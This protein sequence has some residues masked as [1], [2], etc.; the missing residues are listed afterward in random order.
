[1]SPSLILSALRVALEPRIV[2]A[3]GTL[4]TAMDLEDA[5]DRLAT[6]PDRWRVILT[7]VRGDA[8]GEQKNVEL[9]NLLAVVQAH[10]GM[11]S[12]KKNKEDGPLLEKLEKVRGLIAAVR[13]ALPPVLP[14]TVPT[15]QHPEIDCAGFRRKSWYR[16]IDPDYPTRQLAA[17]FTMWYV[18]TG[19]PEIIVSIAPAS[20]GSGG[21]AVKLH[22]G[23][24]LKL[25]SGASM[26]RH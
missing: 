26:Q 18:P 14:A 7:L 11:S 1:V 24:D 25:H 12:T 2:A 4:E 6:A 10:R 23:S 3:G 9:L 8:L 20:G 5:H 15:F 21:N 17:E 19:E 13:F 22:D 16:L